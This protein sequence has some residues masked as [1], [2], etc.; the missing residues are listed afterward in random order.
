MYNGWAVLSVSVGLRYPF[1]MFLLHSYCHNHLDLLLTNQSRLESHSVVYHLNHSSIIPS[2]SIYP[3]SLPK[4][5]PHHPPQKPLQISTTPLPSLPLPPSTI[6]NPLLTIFTLPSPSTSP[7]SRPS[8]PPEIGPMSELLLSL[9]RRAHFRVCFRRTADG[10]SDVRSYTVLCE[11]AEIEEEGNEEEGEDEDWAEAE[12]LEL[13]ISIPGRLPLSTR[14]LPHS[15]IPRLCSEPPLLSE[16]RPTSTTHPL[17]SRPLFSS[18]H[19]LHSPPRSKFHGHRLT[20]SSPA[21]QSLPQPL[22][23]SGP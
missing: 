4:I 16:N 13:G 18:E 9:P 17:R 2:L 7:S 10:L 15:S 8:P 23:H 1:I 14:L 12:A 6:H 20:P 21:A 22:P 3:L 11:E 19:P 5:H